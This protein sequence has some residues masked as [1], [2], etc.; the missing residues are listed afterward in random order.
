MDADRMREMAM[1]TGI[2]DPRCHQQGPRFGQ[3]DVRKL[4]CHLAPVRR[5][6]GTLQCV[7][8]VAGGPQHPA[9][10]RQVIVAPVRQPRLRLVVAHLGGGRQGHGT[11]AP[12]I[13]LFTDAF[14]K[15]ADLG[16]IG[17][18]PVGQ[19]GAIL[20][21]APV[22]MKMMGQPGAG[23]NRM[24]VLTPPPDL[25][26]QDVGGHGHVQSVHAEERPRPGPARLPG[27]PEPVEK[28]QPGVELVADIG[29]PVGHLG[30][31]I[32]VVVALPGRQAARVGRPDTLEGGRR[33]STAG[34]AAELGHAGIVGL[35]DRGFRKPDL[36]P[37][38]VVGP[39]CGNRARLVIEIRLKAC[40]DRSGG[41]G[42]KFRVAGGAGFDAPGTGPDIP[43]GF[44]GQD[45]GKGEVLEP[46]LHEALEPF[47]GTGLWLRVAEVPGI[48]LAEIEAAGGR[49][50]LRGAAE[51]RRD[52]ARDRRRSRHLHATDTARFRDEGPQDRAVCEIDPGQTGGPLQPPAG[53]RGLEGQF[54]PAGGQPRGTR[55]VIRGL[56]QG[57]ERVMLA[58]AMR[59]DHMVPG[60]V[61]AV[62]FGD[63]PQVPDI[64]TIQ[65]QA[66]TGALTP[67][68][69]PDPSIPD[70]QS[71]IRGGRRPV[72]I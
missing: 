72:L 10:Q 15:A 49:Q 35:L 4:A 68:A 39:P 9:K 51:R 24:G 19:E 2:V 56:E 48:V 60:V 55:P 65:R 44:M 36:A 63:W 54:Q 42:Q 14:D 64:G 20:A 46:L 23:G 5:L 50:A 7:R 58:R 37:G 38:P 62:V 43:M 52:Q 32:V 67:E 3:A 47:V 28:P 12:V 41:A 57:L 40:G 1:V 34:G 25:A 53:G 22:L 66:H 33:A 30:V 45:H 70:R 69:G 13:P 27:V 71:L 16:E 17:I 61:R 26:V 21:V 59:L 8:H 29:G 31:Q 6:D 18:G 11:K